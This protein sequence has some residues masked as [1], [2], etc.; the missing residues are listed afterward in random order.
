MRVVF[1]KIL[2]LAFIGVLAIACKPSNPVEEQPTTF[3]LE[4][5]LENGSTISSKLDSVEAYYWQKDNKTVGIQRV[6]YNNGN[7]VFELPIPLAIT[8]TKNIVEY[9]NEVPKE[10]LTITDTTTLIAPVQLRG[11]KGGVVQNIQ[12]HPM[13]T[14]AGAMFTSGVYLYSDR[15]CEV[16]MDK[17]V[18]DGKEYT[19]KLN[20]VKGYNLVWC[21][22]N[23]NASTGTQIFLYTTE[24]LG[25]V[26]WS[27]WG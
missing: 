4:M 10:S 23:F 6:P 22:Q 26:Q 7:V 3:K 14:V 13:V 19:F 15:A 25:D 16:T 8:N 20:L 11:T 24:S 27:V 12:F 2:L 18:F 17:K 21:V 5:T 9:Y 1:E